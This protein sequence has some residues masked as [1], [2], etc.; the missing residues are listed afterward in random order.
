MTTRK[1]SEIEETF[2]EYKNFNSAL[3]NPKFLMPNVYNS[4]SNRSRSNSSTFSNSNTMSG[5]S[6]TSTI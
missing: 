3:L 1:K 2:L 6:L 4:N 5:I